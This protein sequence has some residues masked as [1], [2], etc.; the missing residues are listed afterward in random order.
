MAPHN[1]YRC[2]GED[3]W[4][5]I[6]VATDEEWDAF[7][8]V[9]GNPSWAKEPRFASAAE[10]WKY[11]AELD[12]LIED[13]TINCTHFEVMEILQKAG[14]AAMP[15]FNAEELFNNP[16][17]DYR[18]CWAKIRHPIAGEKAALAPSWKLSQTPAKI[19]S[20]A[21]L[22]GQHTSYVLIMFSKNYWV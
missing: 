16:H 3:K 19:D 13:W 11:Q 9:L 1:C 22:F 10:R 12:K 20:P 6:A 8:K 5:S 21:P 7:C 2:K 15:C 4:I 14:V 17:L 18:E